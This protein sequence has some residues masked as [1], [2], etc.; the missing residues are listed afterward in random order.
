MDD[1]FTIREKVMPVSS[2]HMEEA[3][4]RQDKLTKPAGSLGALEELSVKI[5]GIA[6][7]ARPRLRNKVVCVFAADHGVAEEGV[8]AYPSEVTAQMVYNFLRGGAAINVLARHAAA[9]VVVIDVGV[10]SLLEPRPGLIDRKIGPGTKNM[11]REKAMTRDEAVQALSVGASI[12]E[13]E[14]A[15]G[16]DILALGEMGIANTTSAAA[17][18]SVITGSPPSKV[19]GRGTGIDDERLFRKIGVIEKAIGLHEPD[20]TDAIDVLQKVGGFEIGAIAGAVIGA[21]ARHI[22]VVIDGFISTAGALLAGVF[23]PTALHYV[24][25][26]HTSRETGHGAM[27]SFMGIAPLFDF[28]M[29]LGEGTGACIAMGLADAACRLLDEMATFDEAGVAEKA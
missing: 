8:S 13:S 7:N 28:G 16:L 6:R 15:N 26:S 22:P 18:A 17:I 25:A 9:R 12:V 1:I 2:G 3:K 10:A 5:A 19:A 24:I 20:K 14:I 23:C 11:A 4:A 29:R 27:L 21:A